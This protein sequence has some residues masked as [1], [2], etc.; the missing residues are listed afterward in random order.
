MHSISTNITI[1]ASNVML[2]ESTICVNIGMIKN[3]G[4]GP[5]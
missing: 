2:M 4:E 3:V 5:L 1:I